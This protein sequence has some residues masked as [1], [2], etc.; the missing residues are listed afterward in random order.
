MS[1]ADEEDA[2]AQNARAAV[3]AVFDSLP[4]PLRVAIWDAVGGVGGALLVMAREYVVLVHAGWT[5]HRAAVEV[6]RRVRRWDEDKVR[7][8]HREMLVRGHGGSPHVKAR[9]TILRDADTPPRR[10][11]RPRHEAHLGAPR[12]DHFRRRTPFRR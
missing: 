12:R 4:R 2:E 11:E 6:A 7:D 9:A 3:A 1:D 10:Q 8:L 5:E